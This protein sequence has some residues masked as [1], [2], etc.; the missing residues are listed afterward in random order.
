ML[1][2]RLLDAQPDETIADL[3]AAPGGKATAILE[4]V[5]P[6]R[7]F[8]LANEPIRGR[9]AALQWTL[10]RVGYSRYATSQYDVEQLSER[11]PGCFDKVLVD[12]PCSGQTLVGRGKQS[13]AS[14]DTNQIQHSAARQKRIVRA[15]AQLLRP[16][17]KLVYSTCT[18]AVEEN[19]QVAQTLIDA[20]ARWRVVDVD[21]LSDWKSLIQPGGYRL[22]P[23]RDRCAGAY[24]VCLQLQADWHRP[25]ST[26]TYSKNPRTPGELLDLLEQ[27]GTLTE[28][29]AV[30]AVRQWFT[31]PADA[32]GWLEDIQFAGSE[33]AYKP[34]KVW[35]PAHSLSLRRE[36]TWKPHSRIELSNND[37]QRYLQGNTLDAKELGWSVVSWQGNP[38][39]WVHSNANRANNSLPQAARLPYIAPIE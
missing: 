17:G 6:G 1:A 20:D 3:C 31:I 25:E 18:F 13:I 7:G 35:V 14:F 19:E 34:S 33:V 15:A 23:H 8:L 28:F 39:G 36:S 10:G 11:L 21:E 29:T 30:E 37:A 2:L 38:L 22:W 26:E 16:G 4:A 27:A 5:G 24:A 12:A 32:P 9:A